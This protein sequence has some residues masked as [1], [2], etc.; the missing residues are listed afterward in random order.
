MVSHR[1]AEWVVFGPQS[2]SVRLAFANFLG[3]KIRFGCLPCC[4]RR[5]IAHLSGAPAEVADPECGGFGMEHTP[6]KKK[7][8]KKR[9][10]GAFGPFVLPPQLP[11]PHPSLCVLAFTFFNFVINYS[12]FMW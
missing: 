12:F 5:C 2:V 1:A 3:A 9:S 8:E 6:P 7:K 4:R 10:C 11:L